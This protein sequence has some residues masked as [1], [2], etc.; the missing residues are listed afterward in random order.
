LNIIIYNKGRE[1]NTFSGWVSSLA[2]LPDESLA[3]GQTDYTVKIWNT[4]TRKLIRTLYGH[5][6]EVWALCLLK[7][8]N[9][10]SASWDN[11][12]VRFKRRRKKRTEKRVN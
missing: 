3:S 2:V 11:G 5:S 6:R 8:G 4:T 9:L 1:I 7:D 12:T 10:A